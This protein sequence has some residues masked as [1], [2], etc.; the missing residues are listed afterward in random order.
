MNCDIV[1]NS[2]P[3]TD[4]LISLPSVALLA[5]HAHADR[6]ACRRFRHTLRSP[7]SALTGARRPSRPRDTHTSYHH[8]RYRRAATASLLAGQLADLVLDGIGS[9]LGVGRALRVA[10]VVG[11]LGQRA[12]DALLQHV[13]LVAARAACARGPGVRPA[14]QAGGC[15]TIIVSASGL[16]PRRALAAAQLRQALPTAQTRASIPCCSP[17]A[18]S[19][20]TALAVTTGVPSRPAGEP[21][22][23]PC[24]PCSP[25]SSQLHTLLSQCTLGAAARQAAHVAERLANHIPAGRARSAGARVGQGLMQAAPVTSL[26]EGSLPTRS[27]PA[28]TA[29]PA[30][31]SSDRPGIASRSLSPMLSGDACARAPRR[32]AL[33]RA[34]PNQY[35]MCFSQTMH[36][37]AA[38]AQCCI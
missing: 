31:G 18:C 26:L 30:F 27:L 25:H 11:R 22:A 21:P 35:Y 7:R 19:S 29:S 13:G 34:T 24:L 12:A 10:Q 33:P 6:C 3:R 1:S 4:L 36:R 23:F 14:P 38:L 37:P 9:G 8:R 32:S 15:C 28:C 17:S 20:V 2:R 5:A 16:Q